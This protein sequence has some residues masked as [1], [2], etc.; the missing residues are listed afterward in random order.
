MLTARPPH[1]RQMDVILEE[2]PEEQRAA[3][4]ALQEALMELVGEAEDDD[5]GEEGEEGE[6]AC[7]RQS[8]PIRPTSTRS[9]SRRHTSRRC[10]RR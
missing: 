8:R 6:D 2:I 1:A 10:A 3:A 9:T 7:A 5:E 4:R